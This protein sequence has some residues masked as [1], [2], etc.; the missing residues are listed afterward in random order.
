MFLTVKKYLDFESINPSIK[1]LSISAFFTGI[2]LGYFFTLLVIVQKLNEYSE[3]V[4]GII[5]ASF[6]FGLMIAGFFVSK[7]LAKMGLYRMLLLSVILQTAC[8]ISI[9]IYFNAI[10]LALCSFIMGVMG[11]MNWMTMD[12]WV[13]VVSND[14]NRGKAIGLYNSSISIGF[15]IGPLLV[16]IFGTQGLFPIMLCLLLM[17]IRIPALYI[18]KTHINNVKIPKQVIKINFSFIKVAPFIFVAIF[19][20]GINDS[21]FGALFPAFMINEFFSDRAIGLYFFIGLFGGVISQPFIGALT[22]KVD[23]R[24]F[25]FILL[26][27]HIVWPLLLF[28]FIDMPLMISLSVIIWGFASISL[29]TVALAYLGERVD[30]KEI[31][32]ATSLF[33][34]TF[35]AGE[36]LGPIIVGVSMNT[37]GNSGFI[38]SIL[39]I[40]LLSLFIGFIR[41]IYKVYGNSNYSGK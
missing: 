34:I 41:S 27:C 20:G 5:S 36:F 1:Y 9:F 28:N 18:I 40:T 22:D 8:V 4:I 39:L 10:N 23:K 13:N 29:Y 30:I 32:I 2:A 21:S 37:Y 17:V 38:Y 15:A 7:I 19:I 12:T 31:S 6:S 35:E 33:I 26:I 25:L 24:N 3:S 14:K 16:A 11:G